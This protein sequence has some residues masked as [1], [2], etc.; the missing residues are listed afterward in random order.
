MIDESATLESAD[1][2]ENVHV[3][4]DAVVRDSTVDHSVIFPDTTI[5]DC[6]VRQ[7]VIDEDTHLVGLDLSEALIGAHTHISDEGE[8]GWE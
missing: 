6:E 4:D 7:S 5:E 2:G 3:M 8:F 1:I